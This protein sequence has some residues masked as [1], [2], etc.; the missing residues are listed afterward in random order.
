MAQSRL[1]MTDEEAQLQAERDRFEKL[2]D[3]YRQQSHLPPGGD[4]S[5][6][7]REAMRR[8]A[9]DRGYTPPPGDSSW[10]EREAA[11]AANPE[12]VE[13]AA[14]EPL[15]EEIADD[16]LAGEPYQPREPVLE[17]LHVAKSGH[18]GVVVLLFVLIAGIGIAIMALAYPQ[19]L[20]AAYWR[21]PRAQTITPNTP[22]QA[23]PALPPPAASHD[24]PPVER[25]PPPLD[26]R[27]PLAAPQTAPPSAAPPHATTAP[28]AQAAPPPP[29]EQAPPPSLPATKPVTNGKTSTRG[30]A[31]DDRSKG[32]YAKVPGPDGTLEYQFFPFDP[33]MDPRRPAPKEAA[34]PDQ[35][36]FYAKA[37]GPDGTMQYRYFPSK[38][39]R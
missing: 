11:F 38:P 36:G 37:P 25:T 31:P 34:P 15:R 2:A 24:I 35:G 5:W 21:T 20:T 9:Y 27:G 13:E 30:P 18:G 39:P 3:Q 6:R 4:Q 8:A 17:P 10:R 26:L 19:M 7:E 16:V 1:E 32:F 22:L 23:A 14:Q 28:P 33:K 29:V 12:P